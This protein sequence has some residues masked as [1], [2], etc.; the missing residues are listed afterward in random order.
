MIPIF[1]IIGYSKTGKTTYIRKIVR[2]LQLKG[3]KVAVIKHD[4]LDHGDVDKAGSDTSYFFEEGSNAVVLSS[5]SRLSI[6]RRVEKDTPPEEIIPLCGEV[7]C[8]ILEGYKRWNYPKIEIWSSRKGKLKVNPEQ[9]L[10]L[11]YDRAEEKD[12]LMRSVPGVPVF[13]RDDIRGIIDFLEDSI[14]KD[15]AG[16]SNG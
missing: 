4:P 15:K 6:F 3:Y 7:D 12:T 11:V 16:G 8:A 1:S 10:A 2:E 14:L 5:P 9:L 13:S